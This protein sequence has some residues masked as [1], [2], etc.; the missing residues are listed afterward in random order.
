LA[1]NSRQGEFPVD[2][3]SGKPANVAIAA[4]IGIAVIVASGFGYR[5]LADRYNRPSESVPIARGTLAKI[6]MTF[7]GWFG[8]DKPLDEAIIRA[9]DT[10]DQVN[11]EYR[12]RDGRAAV[13]LFVAYGV[14]LRDLQPH[15]P[16]VCYPGA[17][18]T[19]VDRLRPVLKTRQGAS[20]PVQI[21]RFKRGG[22]AEERVVVLNYYIVDGEYCPDVSLLRSNAWKLSL[23]ANYSAQVQVTCNAGLP[24][25]FNEA[26]A[27]VEAFAT[28][29]AST[30]HELIV[31]SVAAAARGNSKDE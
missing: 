16:E 4:G 20:L 18:W 7:D 1:D 22:L 6:P 25:D 3:A 31:S 21:H 2:L 27:I 28:E 9:I 26:E 30:I 19:L 11:R 17:G 12:R 10:N 8:V 23:Q 14:R 15:R 29:S 5:T 24:R 13:T